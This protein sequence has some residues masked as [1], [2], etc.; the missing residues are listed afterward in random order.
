MG[1]VRAWRR[2]PLWLRLISAM[3]C[4][5]ALGLT[6]TG[7]FGVRLL[8]NYLVD[9]VDEQ[10]ADGVRQIEAARQQRPGRHAGPQSGDDL[11]VPSQFDVTILVADG[12]ERDELAVGARPRS[13]PTSPT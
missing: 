3:L 10:L 6:L 4:L 13:R 2:T 12:A 9:R 8:R 1:P 11:V 5:V 7:A